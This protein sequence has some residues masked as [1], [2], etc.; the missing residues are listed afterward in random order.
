[1]KTDIGDLGK[2]IAIIL[3]ALLGG[4]IVLASFLNMSL[5]GVGLMI[6]VFGILASLYGV[7]AF[8]GKAKGAAL[9][10]M[11][12]LIIVVLFIFKGPDV[13]PQLFSAIP[14][15]EPA[16][17]QFAQSNLGGWLKEN[18]FVTAIVGAGWAIYSIYWMI[19]A[20]RR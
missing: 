8:K 3:I 7:I 12:P 4:F 14:A 16:A 1:M 20:K 9:I 2:F 17:N 18:W 15:L 19:K 11:I 10:P 13:A 6:I 5:S